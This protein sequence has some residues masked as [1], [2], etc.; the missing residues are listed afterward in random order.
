MSI[1]ALNAGLNGIHNGMS[2]LRRDA[3]AVAQAINRDSDSPADVTGSLV[4]LKMD[5]LQVQSSAKVV[6]TVHDLLG[7]LLDVKA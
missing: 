4:N 1:P 5:T 6:D 2:N 7:F 3:S